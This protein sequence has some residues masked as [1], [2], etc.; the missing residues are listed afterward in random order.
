MTLRCPIPSSSQ[1]PGMPFIAAAPHASS[2]DQRRTDA[3]DLRQPMLPR[4]LRSFG[5]R[6]RA[7]PRSWSPTVRR[8]EELHGA[9]P[10]DGAAWWIP[11]TSLDNRR[12]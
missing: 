6:V 9:A 1:R 3:S 7:R 5:L 8:Q 2:G 12:G 10:D 4:R 11:S